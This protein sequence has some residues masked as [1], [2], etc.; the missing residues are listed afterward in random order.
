MFIYNITYNKLFDFHY[1]MADRLILLLLL[2]MSLL[3][4]ANDI[5]KPS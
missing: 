4:T 2:L 5:T 3:V 1:T